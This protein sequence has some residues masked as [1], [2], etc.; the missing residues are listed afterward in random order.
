MKHQGHNNDLALKQSA[1]SD[2]G[3]TL[4]EVMVALAVFSIAVVA[5]ITAQNENIR[6]ITILEERA[7]AEIALE[8]ILV[9]TVTSPA[10]I[11]VGFTSGQV[12]YAE[13]IFDWRRQVIETSSPNVH[14]V[15]ISIY[16]QGG[17]QA[18]QSFTALRKAD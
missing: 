7:F 3:F 15:T 1:S 4:V 8:N 12:T 2:E 11:P 14:R 10:N 5:M 6:T 16:N 17:E 13:R 18:L 9:E